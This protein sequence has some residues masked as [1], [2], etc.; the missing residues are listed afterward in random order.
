MLDD[1]L[2]FGVLYAV[3]DVGLGRSTAE[4]LNA[5]VRAAID[6]EIENELHGRRRAG[7]ARRRPSVGS[8]ALVLSALLTIAFA[9]G[10]IALLHHRSGQREPS[11]ASANGLIARLAVLRRTQT[12]ADVLPAHLKLVHPQ[13]KIIPS[14]TRL[15]AA[16]A[17]AKLF[18][19]VSTPATGP[20][21][22][23]SPT[24]GDQVSVVTVTKRGATQSPPIPSVDLSNA[25]EVT[26]GGVVT[27]GAGPGP[28][29]PLLRDAYDVAVVPDGVSRVR[30]T[31]TDVSG[32]PGH[33]LD[34]NLIN[35]VAYA[36][37][38]RTGF[39]LRA[40][41]YAA[42]GSVIPTSDRALRRANATRQNGL[43][44]AMI[45]RYARYS[46]RAAPAL[47]A[48]FAVF[49]VTSRTGVR[50]STGLTISRPRLSTLPYP[51]VNFADPNQPPQLDPRNIRQITTPSGIRVWVIPG[52]RGLCIAALDRLP[53][54]VH[55]GIATGAGEACSANLTQ[56]E[57]TGTGLTSGRPGGATITYRVL[58]KSKPTVTIRTGPHT[59]RTV[60][61]PY[62]IYVA[63]SKAHGQ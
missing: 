9:I 42:D 45:R 20:R 30:W 31:F 40:T 51:I 37:L 28:T 2:S 13:G 26:P 44:A 63:T 53:F 11:A 49:A 23:W 38:H 5:R 59:H 21:S 58:P 1:N 14:L 12:A 15:V 43:R 25:Q 34:A 54:A 39:L 17:G 32:K 48:D 19:V 27:P 55:S 60:T 3:R 29:R 57:T 16:P 61:P 56:A 24:L 33:V 46:Y 4:G 7:P 41:W 47:L 35:N 6:H 52:Q 18:L 22:L 62:G 36:P 8:L 10:A 50:T